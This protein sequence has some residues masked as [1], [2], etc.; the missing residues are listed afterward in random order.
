MKTKT[1]REFENYHLE[2]LLK[3]STCNFIILHGFG[4]YFEHLL[5]IQPS[6]LTTT[7]FAKG[8]CLLLSCHTLT[9]W[10]P[11]LSRSIV[12]T[13]SHSFIHL[14]SSV[15]R[16]RYLFYSLCLSTLCSF[17]ILLPGVSP[18]FTEAPSAGS[19]VWLA[20]FHHTHSAAV[21]Y[22]TTDSSRASFC[23]SCV[24]LELSIPPKELV[25]FSIQWYKYQNSTQSTF[26][27]LRGNSIF[28]NKIGPLNSQS[29]SICGCL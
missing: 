17:F 1:R 29:H 21:L 26:I 22:S 19:S 6:K 23:F 12:P 9:N 5:I 16:P 18:L 14:V 8:Y 4:H 28:W 7:T 20:V 11:K 3:A 10:R 27:A 15:W 13:Y 25:P 24:S 2:R